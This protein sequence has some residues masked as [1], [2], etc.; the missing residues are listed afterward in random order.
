MHQEYKQR[1]FT[2][3]V[4]AVVGGAF[5][6]SACDLSIIA[7]GKGRL[8]GKVLSD[9]GTPLSRAEVRVFQNATQR[10]ATLSG[11]KGEYEFAGLASGIFSLAANHT[12]Y[13]PE[14]ISPVQVPKDSDRSLDFHL[15]KEQFA[16]N[17]ALMNLEEKRATRQL[18]AAKVIGDTKETFLLA[19][20][21][22]EYYS[23]LNPQ[24]YGEYMVES[25]VAAERIG[26]AAV[27]RG[28]VSDKT[29]AV[30]PGALIEV[31]NELTGEARRLTTDSSGVYTLKVFPLGTYTITASSSGLGR[32]VLPGIRV[33]ETVATTADA[34]IQ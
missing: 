9:N 2:I 4:Y 19:H 15:Q 30:I 12:T 5:L 14:M 29:G 8:W 25:K 32:V 23:T 33:S 11:D 34:Q 7:A 1:A 21:L 26:N 24:L 28:Q 3:F 6:A 10:K 18:T 13:I 22:R 16:S 31:R 20:H 27:L 17:G